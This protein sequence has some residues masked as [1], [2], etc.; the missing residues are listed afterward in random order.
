VIPGRTNLTGCSMGEMKRLFSR[1]RYLAAIRMRRL[2]KLQSAPQHHSPKNAIDVAG[3]TRSR[4]VTSSGLSEVERESRNVSWAHDM[5]GQLKKALTHTD[6]GKFSFVRL[7][8]GPIDASRKSL[9]LMNG[10]LVTSTVPPSCR[11]VCMGRSSVT[12]DL[13]PARM[14]RRALSLRWVTSGG[15]CV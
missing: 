6:P 9:H 14:E 4:T 3:R 7:R 10:I 11:H 15:S 2:A 1:K 8:A 13:K 12:S 5:E